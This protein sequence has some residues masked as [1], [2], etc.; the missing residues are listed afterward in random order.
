MGLTAAHALMIPRSAWAFADDATKHNGLILAMASEQGKQY[1]SGDPNGSGLLS[2]LNPQ[3]EKVSM[4]PVP[5]FG[6]ELVPHPQEKDLVFTLSKKGR[7]AALINYKTRKVENLVELTDGTRFNGHAVFSRDGKF[8]Y[9]TELQINNMGFVTKR[10]AQD[11]S[12]VEVFPSEGY[13]PHQL[14]WLEEDKSL[15]VINANR[16]TL[17][18][19]IRQIDLATKKN[20]LWLDLGEGYEFSHFEFLQYGLSPRPDFLC[21]AGR[22]S[23]DN[24]NRES[25]DTTLMVGSQLKT[26]PI[27]LQDLQGESISMTMNSRLN[28][29]LGSSFEGGE[30][31]LYDMQNKKTFWRHRAQDRVTG[32]AFLPGDEKIAVCDRTGFMN[33]FTLKQKQN[34]FAVTEAGKIPF[35][36]SAHILRL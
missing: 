24:T 23:S 8:I 7:R 28:L 19:Q 12:V 16:A 30:V 10:A 17:R 32:V 20:T 18:S 15:L 31:F 22:T 4:M 25:G 34:S 13:S 11:L 27:P 6:H 2:L 36:S 33:L 26:E 3:S 21:A 14:R 35:R 29:V 9:C 1:T 5:L